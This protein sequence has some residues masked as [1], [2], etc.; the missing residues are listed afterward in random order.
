M[1]VLVVIAVSVDCGYGVIKVVM[2]VKLT[3]RY[4]VNV[5]YWKKAFSL[6]VSC[7]TKQH[8]LAVFTIVDVIFEVM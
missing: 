1:Y 4:E 2:E 8:G 6:T 7:T 3:T 5:S